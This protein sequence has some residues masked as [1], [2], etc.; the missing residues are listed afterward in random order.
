VSRACMKKPTAT[1]QRSAV[2]EFFGVILLLTK[3]YSAE[4]RAM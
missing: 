3:R 2:C 1:I 4:F